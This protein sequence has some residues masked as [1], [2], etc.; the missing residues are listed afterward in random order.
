MPYIIET[1]DKPGHGHVRQGNRKAHLDYVDANVGAVVAAGAKLMDDG[2]DAGGGVYI[3]D[4]ETKK[5]AEDFIENDPFYKAGLFE[6]VSITRW[7]K[8]YVDGACRL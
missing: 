6:K 2:K 7:R 1:W 5:E 8:A 3:V 4:Y